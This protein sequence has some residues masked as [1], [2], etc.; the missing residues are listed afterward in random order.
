MP[1]GAAVT[2]I[3]PSPYI[4]IIVFAGVVFCSSAV[5]YVRHATGL[6]RCID[7]RFPTLWDKLYLRDFY[8]ARPRSLYARRLQILVLF[9]TAAADH[10]DDP[11]FKWHLE[12]ARWSIAICFLAFVLLLIAV[13]RAFPQS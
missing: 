8:P 3:P 12:Q 7:E 13:G 5:I 1:E 6:A 2:S 4:W 10:P 11:E 9:N